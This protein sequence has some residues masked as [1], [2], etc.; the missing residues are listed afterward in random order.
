MNSWA[1]RRF[2]TAFVI[3]AL[4]ITGL[5]ARSS[6]HDAADAAW[7]TRVLELGPGSVVGEI[8]AG[9]GGVTFALATTVAESGRVFTNELNKD[10]VKAIEREA[11]KSGVKNVT[12]VEGRETETNFPDRCCDAIFMRAVYHHFAD[13]PAM[14]ASLLKSLKPGGRLAV[15]DF[16]PPPPS[17]V[18]ENPAGKRGEDNHHGI[19]LATLQ[20]ELKA[21]GFEIVSA[22]QKSRAV[23]VVARRPDA[24]SW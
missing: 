13:P 12:I 16:T 21:A 22:E 9:E 24:N 20:K 3:S 15:I 1:F 14:N 17:D 11:D 2:I 5:L 4:S 23:T 6:R 10:R 7:L 8:G 19:T 18:S